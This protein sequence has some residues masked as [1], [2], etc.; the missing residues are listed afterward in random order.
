[1]NEPLAQWALTKQWGGGNGQGRA[2]LRQNQTGVPAFTVLQVSQLDVVFS[3]T[4][5]LSSE[6]RLN[7]HWS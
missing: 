5:A 2:S 7:V 3:Y 4:K 1:M 6:K